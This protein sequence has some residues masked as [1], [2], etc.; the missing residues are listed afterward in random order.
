MEEGPKRT[1]RS[2]V[3]ESSTNRNHAPVLQVWN[4]SFE[5]LQPI[6]S[7][8]NEQYVQRRLKTNLLHP[9][10]GGFGEDCPF[11]A[12]QKATENFYSGL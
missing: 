9:N 8:R 2:S 4:N 12:F 3:S 5:K 10:E 6:N 7:S 11:E 1:D